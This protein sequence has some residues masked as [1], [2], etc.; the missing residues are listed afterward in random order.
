MVFENNYAGK[1]VLVTG[2]TGFKGSWLSIWLN[3]LGADV[4]GMSDQIPTNPSNYEVCKIDNF[5]YDYRIDIKN[6]DEVYEVIE[7]HSPDYIFNLAAQPL[8][9]ESYLFPIETFFTN[10]IGSANILNSVRKINKK[11]ICVMITSDKVYRNLELKRG[12]D[13][14]DLIGG[15]DPYSASKGMA[16]LAIYSFVESYFDND[17]PIKVAVGRAGNVIGGGDWAKD[18][19]VPDCVSA[20][21]KNDQLKI[22]NPNSTR[23]WQHVLEPLSGYLQLGAIM[24]SNAFLHGETFNFGPPDENDFSVGY[25]IKKM[26]NQW[27]KSRWIN[28]ENKETNIK[29]AGL[30]K[31]NCN[32]AK[33][34]IDWSPVMSFDETVKMTI[35]WY[36]EFYL[37]N[38]VDM[39]KYTTMQIND[40]TNLAKSRK[41]SWA[42]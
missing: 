18:R 35:D 25:L 28:E 31:L 12:Y 23:P 13:E 32:K 29:E 22:R 20:W 17:S 33:E 3:F 5:V 8:V 9:R 14:N 15:K 6:E 36:K 1:K 11:T 27:P 42:I 10:A 40:Y 2:H 24:D 37:E 30:L 4:I 7:K 38:K 19:I 26:S 34:N 21:S 41:I 39:Y 16:E